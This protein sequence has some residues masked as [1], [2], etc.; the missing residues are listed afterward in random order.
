MR[1]LKRFMEKITDWV[2]LWRELV[3]SYPMYAEFKKN[4]DWAEKKLE[5]F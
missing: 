2:A 5:E 1:R 3:E 4:L